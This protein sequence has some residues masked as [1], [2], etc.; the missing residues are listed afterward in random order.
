MTLRARARGCPASLR[1]VDG[2][3]EAERAR[4]AGQRRQESGE[5]VDPEPAGLRRVDGGHHLRIEDIDVQV[6]PEPSQVRPG[7]PRQGVVDRLL[8]A[9][10]PDLLIGKVLN[11]RP[12]QRVAP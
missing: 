10:Q 5:I 4:V 9:T 1:V 11:G 3:L 2:D 6:E 8:H 7:E 12:A